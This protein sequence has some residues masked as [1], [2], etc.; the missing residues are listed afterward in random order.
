MAFAVT[1]E[2]V[3]LAVDGRGVVRVGGTRVTLDS[4]VAAFLEGAT[5][6]EIASQYPSL[7]LAD[8]YAAISYYLRH[9]SEVDS[10]LRRRERQA[11]G[12]R[13]R[14]ERRCRPEGIRARLLARRRSRGE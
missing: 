3:P 8:A 4:V 10:Y 11:Q 5:A 7:D 9:R 13:E 14:T 1:Q 12:V 2:G 6:E